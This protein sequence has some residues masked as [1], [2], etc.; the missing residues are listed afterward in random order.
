[1]LPFLDPEGERDWVSQHVGRWQT[2]LCTAKVLVS[3]E[4]AEDPDS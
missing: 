4:E 3:S 2:L 1:M